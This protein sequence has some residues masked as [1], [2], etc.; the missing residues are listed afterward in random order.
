[1]INDRAGTLAALKDA[2][3]RVRKAGLIALDQ[4]EDGRLTRELVVPLLDTGDD[5]L[6]QAVLEVI[7][8]RPGWADAAGA[9]RGRWLGADRLRVAQERALGGAL[10]ALGGEPGIRKLVAGAMSDRGTVTPTRLLLLRVM[11]QGRPDAL[12]DS[13]RAALGQALG[14]DDS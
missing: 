9:L 13:W 2:D 11:A 5:A 8:R 7:A 10:L 3:P 6:H 14:H 4:M 1:R 12:P